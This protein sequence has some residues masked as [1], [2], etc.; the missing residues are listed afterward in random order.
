M[1]KAEGAQDRLAMEWTPEQKV[2]DGIQAAAV[3]YDDGDMCA[4]VHGNLGL[5]IDGDAMAEFF[6][7]AMQDVKMLIEKV[8]A[9]E[10]ESH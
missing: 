8:E 7:H 9:L 4:E 6:S 1:P 3:W 2:N 5:D 10:I